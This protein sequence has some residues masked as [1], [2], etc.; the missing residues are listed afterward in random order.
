MPKLKK[1]KYK[2][3]QFEFKGQ[4]IWAVVR[5]GKKKDILFDAKMWQKLIKKEQQRIL[6]KG[7]LFYHV[8]KGTKLIKWI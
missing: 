2:E 4:K 1:W 7:K 6:K 3:A 5:L 8:P